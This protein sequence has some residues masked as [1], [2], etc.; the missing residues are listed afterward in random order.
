[1]KTIKQFKKAFTM[2]E[3]VFVIAILGIVASISSSVI[4]QVYEAYI[5]QRATHNASIDTELAINQITN[6]LTYRINNSLLARKPG[7]TGI[8]DT[9][10]L[11]IDELNAAQLDTYTGL[12]WI[13]YDHA[14]FSGYQTP[15]WSGFCDLSTSDYNHIDTPGSD[16]TQLNAGSYALVF[17]GRPD[18]R[19]GG[20]SYSTRRCMYHS[21]GCIFPVNPQGSTTLNFTGAGDRVANEMIYTEF[22]QLAKT[23]YAVIPEA[24]PSVGTPGTHG[25][26]MLNNIEVWDLHLYTDYQPWNDENYKDGSDDILIK[27]ISVFRLRKEANSIRVKICKVVPIGDTS[28]ITICKEKAVIR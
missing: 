23:A 7:S 26:R 11:P 28:Q 13:N 2:L 20:R 3:L 16:L 25:G 19:I 5:M 6:R 9:D 15:A 21:N 22:Y 8:T 14:S 27:N 4:V 12:E 1:M 17:M 24:D 10:A 18:Y